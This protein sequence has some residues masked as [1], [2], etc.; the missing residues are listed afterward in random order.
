LNICYDSSYNS[1]GLHGRYGRISLNGTAKLGIANK[2]SNNFYE[3][4]ISNLSIKSPLSFTRPVK[5]FEKNSEA[6]LTGDLSAFS[7]E[8]YVKKKMVSKSFVLPFGGGAYFRLIPLP[9]FR[10]GIKSILK[11]E[12]S[13]LFYLHPWE[14]DPE[15]P[16]VREA[17][18]QQKFRH[19]SKLSKTFARLKLLIKSFNNCAFTTCA[20]YIVAC[21]KHRT[22]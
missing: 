3:L 19:Y 13:Y 22:S 7:S 11:K 9:M 17:S 5:L 14:I 12:G 8:R 20:E 21:A 6:N 2:L 18:L 15:Q 1:F 10:L 4:P 16:R